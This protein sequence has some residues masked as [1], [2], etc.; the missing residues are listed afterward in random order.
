MSA[1]IDLRYLAKL[2][3]GQLSWYNRNKAT[4]IKFIKEF[5]WVKGRHLFI[6][7]DTGAGKT[8]KGYWLVNWIIRGSHRYLETVVWISTGKSGEILPLLFL[9]VPVRII[10]P[11]GS[12]IAILER[13]AGKWQPFENVEIVEV[14][15]AGSAWWA[16]KRGYIN[17]MEFRNTISP[18]VRLEWMRVLFE[19]LSTWTLENKM[20]KILP[21][22]IFGDEVRWFLAGTR[23][24]TDP[25]RN[26]VSETVTENALGVRSE[27]VRLVI[28]GQGFKDIPPAM[29]DNLNCA[30]IGRNTFV[31]PDE[32]PKIARAIQK[33]RSGKMPSAYRPDEGTFVHADGSTYPFNQP[34][35]FPLFPKKQEDRERIKRMMVKYG[36]KFGEDDQEEETAMECEPNLG[37]YQALAFKPEEEEHITRF[38]IPVI[39]DD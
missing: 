6:I 12:P 8:Q 9:G 16:C 14:S 37:R 35:P 22:A 39:A 1:G 27:G 19:T 33:M 11:K 34:W 25:E 24:T 3:E 23:I 36:K 10:C 38:D 15:D 5:L 30:I 29:R 7:G 13:V 20:P 2:D 32:S 17:I 26:K 31:S 18:K 28:F 21:L 4:V